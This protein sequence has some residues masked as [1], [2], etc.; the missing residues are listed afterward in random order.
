MTGKT[1]KAL[2]GLEWAINQT[3]VK[4]RQAD[5]WTVEEFSKAAGIP[6]STAKSRLA[7]MI[8]KGQLEKRVISI[9]GHQ[10][11]LYRKI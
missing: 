5:E 4:P 7:S 11:N 1:K 2:T 10:T 8:D 3:V 6:C 9:A